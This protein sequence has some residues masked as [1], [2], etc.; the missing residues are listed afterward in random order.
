MEDLAFPQTDKNFFSGFL[1]ETIFRIRNNEASPPRIPSS[2]A[3]NAGNDT[4][5]RRVDSRTTARSWNDK[6]SAAAAAEPFRIFF[7]CRSRSKPS[8]GRNFRTLRLRS[9]RRISDPAAS[10][11][12]RL[13]DFSSSVESGTTTRTC[14][15]PTTISSTR[16]QCYKTFFVRN[17]RMFVIS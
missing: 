16:G 15:T 6:P 13:A 5:E 12:R 7:S 14:S 8:P 9:D 10:R 11:I 17:L 2:E 3:F 1:P 4:T